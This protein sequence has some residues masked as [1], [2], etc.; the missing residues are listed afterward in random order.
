MEIRARLVVER[1]MDKGRIFD[2]G[3][4]GARLGRSWQNDVAIND[5][6]YHVITAASISRQT[7]YRTFRILAAQTKRC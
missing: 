2:V 6:K 3:K 5:E 7:A 4:D 1:G